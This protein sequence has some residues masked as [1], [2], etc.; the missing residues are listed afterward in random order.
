M[1]PDTGRT[2]ERSGRADGVRILVIW[3]ILSA[4]CMP[5]V[6]FVWGPHLPPGGLSDQ[7][8][9]QRFD[10]K[11]LGTV[12]TPVVL[13]VCTFIIYALV[14]WRQDGDDIEDGPYI[15]NKVRWSGWWVGITTVTVLCLA[16]FG[17]YEL[18]NNNGAGSGS[19]PSPLFAASGPYL[20]VQV[21]AQQWRFTFR[22]PTYGGMETTSLMIPAGQEIQFNVTSLDVIHSFWAYQLGV[23]ADA[24]PGVNNVAFVKAYHPGKFNVMCA[25]LCGLW[26]GAMTADG[27]VMTKAD[28]VA[29]A[30]RTEAQEA[31][32]TKLLPK[33][34]T[35]YAPDETG[36]G[37]TYYGPQYPVNP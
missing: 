15:T 33:Y 19:G 34:S 10:N 28:F 5:L 6:W 9:G 3:L 7:A 32:V 12:A 35:V 18:E 21:I 26:H 29:W 27:Q 30:N 22:Y 25:E 20:P 8:A 2:E 14:N 16:V 23:K 36:A 13:L 17:T 24:N 1:A 37:G 31:P 11:V 4:I